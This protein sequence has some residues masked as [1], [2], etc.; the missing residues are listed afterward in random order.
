[1]KCKK[2]NGFLFYYIEFNKQEYMFYETFRCLNCGY[3][4]LK[5]YNYDNRVVEALNISKYNSNRAYKEYNKKNNKW[6]KREARKKTKQM[7]Y[8]H[9]CNCIF[10]TR[11]ARNRFCSNICRFED[12]R[13]RTKVEKIC[14]ICGLSYLSRKYIKSK[15]CS[16]K[17]RSLLIKLNKV[18]N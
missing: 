18:S 4:Y 3:I 17:C 14:V 12:I 11:N 2:C 15:T 9:K 6:Y 10:L 1:M 5:Q 7:V 13:N 16:R 8:C